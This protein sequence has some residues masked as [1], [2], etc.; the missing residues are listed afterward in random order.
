MKTDKPQKAVKVGDSDK[1]RLGEW[2][3]AIGNPAELQSRLDQLKSQG[4]KVAVLLV[5]NP[6]GETRFVALNLQ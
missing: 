1:L 4:K 3:V 5:S 2:V 6:D